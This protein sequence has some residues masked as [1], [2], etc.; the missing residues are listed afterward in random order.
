LMATHH[1]L[2]S[3]ANQA[4]LDSAIQKLNQ[5]GFEKELTEDQ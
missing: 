3:K 5:Q 2:S 4:R 1:E